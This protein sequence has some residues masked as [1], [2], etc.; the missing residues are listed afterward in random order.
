MPVTQIAR[1][2]DALALRSIGVFWAG[3]VFALAL[4]GCSRA[5]PEQRLRESMAALQAS[6]EARD[7]GE[8]QQ[9]L[10][11][12]FIGPDGLDR[13]GAKRLAQVLLL[14]HREVGVTLGAMEVKLLEHH[15]TVRFSAALTGGSGG[16]LPDAATLYDVKTGWRLDDGQWR[17][18]SASWTPRL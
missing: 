10:A 5:P 15:A 3:L 1:G 4:A 11:A 9:W 16:L 13:D 18:T 8:M 12:D 7:G 6:L 14:R 2:P 17:L